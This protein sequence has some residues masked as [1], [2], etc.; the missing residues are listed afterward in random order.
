MSLCVQVFTE[1]RGS[2][3]FTEAGVSGG[4]V[5]PYADARSHTSVS[6]KSGEHSYVLSSPPAPNHVILIFYIHKFM[7]VTFLCNNKI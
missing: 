7:H 4:S 3:T 1:G 2:V 6:W 5:T